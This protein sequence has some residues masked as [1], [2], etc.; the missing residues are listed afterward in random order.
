MKLDNIDT[1]LLD[2]NGTLYERRIPVPGVKDTIQ[3]LRARGLNLNFIT[4]TDGRSVFDVHK[5]LQSMG[6]D[7]KKE[8]LLTP[9][10]AAKQFINNNQDK[11]F[12]LLVDDDV[13]GDLKHANMDENEPDYVIIGDFSRKLDY[14]TLNKVFRMIK[15]GAEIIALSK[16]LWYVDVDGHSLN[17]GAFVAMFEEACDK[18]GKLLGKPAI[19]FLNMA[20]NRT[21]SIAENTLV[22]GD[23]I[24]TDIAGGNAL[25]A[26]TVLVQ[27]GVYNPDLLLETESKPNYVIKDVNGLVDLLN[28]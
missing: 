27:T 8:E 6:L 5:K 14:D 24:K 22:I 10:S 26:V 23:D 20:L 11:K 16:T 12:Y 25:G 3:K 21:K 15:K 13:L 18:E 7:I 17:T 19:D 9:V 4:N 28:L 2:L 1:L